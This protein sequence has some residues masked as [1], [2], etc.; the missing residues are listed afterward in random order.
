MRGLSVLC[1]IRDYVEENSGANYS[2]H[3]KNLE[4]LVNSLDKE[5]LSKLDG[6]SKASSSSNPAR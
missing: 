6:S 5:I 1:S 3:Y 4:T 2:A